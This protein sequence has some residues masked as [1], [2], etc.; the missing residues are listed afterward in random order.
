MSPPTSASVGKK[1]PYQDQGAGDESSH[2][3]PRIFAASH[4]PPTRT[5]Y[6]YT[7]GPDTTQGRIIPGKS[8]SMI[9]LRAQNQQNAASR[10]PATTMPTPLPL[11]TAPR[12]WPLG[13]PEITTV[14]P[15]TSRLIITPS[16]VQGE[17]RMAPTPHGTNTSIEDK[18]HLDDADDF[19][20]VPSRD[21]RKRN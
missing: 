1:R 15:A 12:S 6:P 20:V 4:S 7:G 19:K 18:V 10:Q 11:T 14:A 17:K 16:Q 5:K 8:L 21:P 13:R 2:M 9:S 3:P